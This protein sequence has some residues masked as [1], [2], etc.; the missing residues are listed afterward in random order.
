MICPCD[1]GG[2][3]SL[4]LV[5]FLAGKG[6]TFGFVRDLILRLKNERN[7]DVV[8]GIR[9]DKGNEFK[10]S[11][12][13][14][15]CRDLGLEHLF[16]SQYVASRNGVVERKNCS[17]CEMARM[18]LDEHRTPRR[19]LVEAVNTACHVRNLIFLRA[20]LNKMCYELMHRRAPR[21]THFGAFNC[22]CFIL[23][24]GRLFILEHFVCSTLILT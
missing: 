15:F 9:S 5:F 11:H 17:V 18:M 23:K 10:S 4:C 19:Y 3:F 2:L 7:G 24:K 8:R 14:I 22:R 20:F 12:F 13:D 1:R 21:V 16:S 6:E